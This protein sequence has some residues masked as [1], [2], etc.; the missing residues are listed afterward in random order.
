MPLDPICA[1]LLAQMAQAGAP[2]LHEQTPAMAREAMAAAG[3]AMGGDPPRVARVDDL[4]ASGPAG[5]IPLRAYYPDGAGP[6]GALVYFHGGGWVI[7]S[8]ETHD[9]LCRALAN[10]TGWAV[11]SVE[12]RLAPEHKY[13]A[14]ADDAYAATAWVAAQAR[15]LGVDAAR[16]A[17]AGD[18]AGGNLAAVVAQ[19]A[20]DRGGPR[21]RAQALIYP[22]TDYDFTTPSYGAN[23]DGY[24]LTQDAMRWFWD[25]YLADARQ[26]SEPYAS[27]LRARDLHG[28]PPALVLTAEFDP[29]RDEGEAYAAALR[30]AGVPVDQHR[31]DGL[32]HG[33]FQFGG[34]FPQAADAQRRVADHLAQAFGR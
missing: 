24:L 3:A 8:I 12:Y 17:V 33:F 32:I 27:P 26:G 34:A 10:T 29:L 22:V 2:P 5:P 13:P 25:H 14:A 11:F 31:Y 20:R 1:A 7:G 16:V 23:A 4:Q 18:S 9:S 19:M 28:L 15:T 6:F 21:L 30:R